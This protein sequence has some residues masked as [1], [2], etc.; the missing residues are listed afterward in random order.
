MTVTSP[1]A[2]P[3]AAGAPLRAGCAALSEDAGEPLTGTAPA[4]RRLVAVEHVG[5]WPRT[6]A[7]HP[8]PDVAELY[9]RLRHEDVLLLLLRRTGRAGRDCDGARTVYVADLAPGASRVTRQ[10]VRSTDDLARI[11]FDPD[12]GEPVTD[13]VMLV[14]A[15]GR[16]DVC[17][18]VRGRALAADLGAEGADV[19]ECTHLGGHRFAPTALV[20]PTGY[21]YGRLD[22]GSGLAAL[23]AAAG[24]GVDPWSCRGHAGLEPVQQVAEL[25]V[26]EHTGIGHAG[27]LHVDAAHEPGPVTVRCTDGRA[28]SVKVLPDGGLPPRPPSC[29]AV[30]EPA[31]PL[32]AG[33]PVEL[34][35]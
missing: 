1:L 5:A 30:L 10:S 16:R 33:V 21:A 26:R 31:E 14:C 17:C 34:G 32:V 7:D 6:V 24:G 11:T 27:A 35:R 9:T 25:A 28:W 20:L 22:T 8:D 15:H 3:R 23:K 2:G 4:A 12:A 18:A 19:W 29:G 13:P